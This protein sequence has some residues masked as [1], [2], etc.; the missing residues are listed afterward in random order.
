MEL[1]DAALFAAFLRSGL[2]HSS[3]YWRVAGQ[4]DDVMDH[5]VDLQVVK[6][7]LLQFTPNMD[8][9]TLARLVSEFCS[10]QS[11]LPITYINI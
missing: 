6:Y 3:F 2:D 1:S 5:F 8:Y 10:T 9:E 4:D 7:Y 11:W